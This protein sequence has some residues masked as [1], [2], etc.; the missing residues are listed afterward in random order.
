M[1]AAR[2]LYP[3]QPVSQSEAAT[4]A[5]W[6]CA[7]SMLVGRQFANENAALGELLG[8]NSSVL[9]GLQ[10][11]RSLWPDCSDDFDFDDPVMLGDWRESGAFLP[12][13]VTLVDRFRPTT[14][15]GLAAGDRQQLLWLMEAVS[16]DALI[17][18]SVFPRWTG[19]C[20]LNLSDAL[21]GQVAATPLAL[22]LPSRIKRRRSI[23]SRHLPAWLFSV[24]DRLCAC[25][26]L[27]LKD[28]DAFPTG[29]SAMLQTTIRRR[30]ESLSE[31]SH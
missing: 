13:A 20:W 14:A 5:E 9:Q 1:W 17:R 27:Y 31:G 15:P 7:I 30:R 29:P 28:A 3:F 12:L 22:D 11:D 24:E 26:E 4:M 16:L 18:G 10:D 6:A 21:D 19:Y 2:V 25:I 23:K 8:L